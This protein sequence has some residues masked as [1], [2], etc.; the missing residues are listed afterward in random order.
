MNFT[1]KVRRKLNGF[2]ISTKI[3]LGYSAC[4]VILLAIINLAMW[5]GVMSAIYSPAGEAIH[6]SMANIQK[7]FDE[8]EEDEST[9][10]PD[11]FSGAL[12][13]G[14]VLKV[15]DEQGNIFIDTDEN[16]Y[17]TI[18]RFNEGILSDPPIFA[19]DDL[20]IMQYGSA[21]IYCGEMSYTHE[22]KT[23][24]LY[25]FRTITSELITFDNL[26]KILLILDVL[27]M[28]AA[29]FV[30]RVI[31]RRVLTPI[32]TMNE[33]AREIA[34]EKMGGRIPLSTADDELNELAK[35]LN[36]ML[37]R[38]QGGINR[39]QQFVSDASHE[40]RTPTAVIK[41]YIDMLTRYGMDDKELVNE[42]VEAIRSEAQ[43]MQE[44][45]EN[46]LFLSRADKHT[47]K[48][49]KKTL[50]LDDIVNDVMSKM[51]TVVKTHKV[52]LLKNEP[53]QIFGDETTM[54]Q[55]IRIF[56]DNAVKYTPEGG[57]I[58]VASTVAGKKVSLSIS[59]T[60]IGIAPENRQK[61][62]D[63][64]FR[65]DSEDLVSEA[66]GSGLGLSI[67]QWIADSHGITIGVDS[68]LGKGTTFTL[69]IPRQ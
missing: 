21:L 64:F 47:Q 4:F 44:L 66:N 41:G 25:F 40:L 28:F 45:L 24:K 19:A 29:L 37:D 27:G 7:I 67:A 43:N 2:E 51:R 5:F 1:E 63:R 35:T 62:F 16:Y 54:R 17:L 39:Q 6:Q 26:E 50:D 20:K 33:L 32:K 42:S 57:T 18:E 56:L 30:G 31:S 60:G 46:L 53:A 52:K 36:K 61:I 9:F 12:V 11:A 68:E 59:D 55:M 8:L 14:V 23:V 69:T 48:L 65:I 15:I 38:L 34:F 22:G 13:R 10:N 49:H 58:S 3:T